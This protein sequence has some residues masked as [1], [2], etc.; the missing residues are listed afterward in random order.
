MIHVCAW[1]KK[2]LDSENSDTITDNTIT[3]GICR[4]CA[5]KLVS[6]EKIPLKEF[7]DTLGV[8]I[9]VVNNEGIVVTAN[10]DACSLL[11][12]NLFEI[13]GNPGG[14]VIE[15]VNAKL[16]G[17]C[18]QQ[19]HCKS[20]T[21]RNTVMHTHAT[22]R[23]HLKVNAYPDIQMHDMVKTLSIKISTEK[24]GDIV[25]LRIDDMNDV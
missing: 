9:L 12:K 18:G 20:C 5:A 13:E 25:L 14:N 11:G 6:P 10:H 3:H 21:I 4:E 22:G 24:I 23:S 8:P 15:C 16:P 7:L 17:G 1:C 2:V 19:I